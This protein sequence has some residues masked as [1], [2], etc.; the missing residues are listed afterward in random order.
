[1]CIGNAKLHIWNW[2]RRPT[3]G[4]SHLLINRLLVNWPRSN[5]L[6]SNLF[7]L[8]NPRKMGTRQ[9]RSC[10]CLIQHD[11]W[12]MST[13]RR[14][15]LMVLKLCRRLLF[16][17]EVHVMEYFQISVGH[18]KMLSMHTVFMHRLMS[19][20]S[21]KLD[22]LVSVAVMRSMLRFLPRTA[23]ELRVCTANTFMEEYY[24]ATTAS[25][26]DELVIAIMWLARISILFPDKYNLYQQFQ[27]AEW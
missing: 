7:W 27:E 19:S 22:V 14:T 20:F 11:Q 16:Q 25:L 6:Y 9:R 1:M 3:R 2:R 12:T 21:T 8:L 23:L 13:L 17:N 4:N 15:L 5:P 26:Y 24:P 10:W 18:W